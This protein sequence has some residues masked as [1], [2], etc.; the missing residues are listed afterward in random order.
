MMIHAYQ[1]IHLNK[2]KKMLGE[3][4][5]HAI[6]TCGI[7]GELFLKMFAVSVFAKQVEKGDP[8]IISGISGIELATKIIED[9]GKNSTEYILSESYEKSCEYWIGWACAHYQW[10]SGRNFADIFEAM[11]YNFLKDLY[12]PLHEADISK[13]VEIAEKRVKDFFPET[14]LKLYRSL[15]ELSQSELAN[16]SGVSLRSIQMYE[17][18]NK[19]INKASAESLLKLSRALNCEMEDLIEY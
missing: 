7:N 15:N 1:E 16:L 14:K 2:V 17:Q 4:F 13:F 6:N 5:D 3:A 9:S 11:S 12:F 18:R 8:S 10:V 19:D